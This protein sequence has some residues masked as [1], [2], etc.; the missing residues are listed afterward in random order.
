M[1]IMKNAPSPLL[2]PAV[3]TIHDP[4][5]EA[6]ALREK[7]RIALTAM[8]TRGLVLKLQRM[9]DKY[10]DPEYL[11]RWEAASSLRVRYYDLTLTWLSM[12]TP[13]PPPAMP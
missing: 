3:V 11:E 7:F 13:S 10:N 9:T 2:F 8:R 1:M 12:T 6:D 4:Y 5:R